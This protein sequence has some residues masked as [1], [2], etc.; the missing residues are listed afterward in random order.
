MGFL[1]TER[2]PKDNKW[3]F[4]G[5]VQLQIAVIPGKEPILLNFQN[6]ST[7]VLDDISETLFL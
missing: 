6:F 4:L 3:K 1:E 2:F 7:L 5:R